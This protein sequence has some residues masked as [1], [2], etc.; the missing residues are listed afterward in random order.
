MIHLLDMVGY[1]NTLRTFGKLT[2][3]RAQRERARLEAL[4]QF[5]LLDAPRDSSFERIVRLIKEIFSVDIGIV[6]VIDAHRQSYQA[7]VGLPNSE[8]PR[9]ESF[10]TLIVDSGVPMIIQDASKDA[11]SQTIHR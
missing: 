4:D 6:S 7:C 3:E 1:M 10:C 2:A 9:E 8:V 5:D 11:G